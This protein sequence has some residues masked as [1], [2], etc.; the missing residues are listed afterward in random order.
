MKNTITLLGGDSRFEYASRYFS[1]RGYEVRQLLYNSDE[2]PESLG[3]TV[4]LPLPVMR[5]GFLFSPKSS[6]K[7]SENELCSVLA[8]SAS[9]FGG[10]VSESLIKKVKEKGADIV[11]YYKNEDLLRANATLTAESAMLLL[12]QEKIPV[13]NKRVLVLGFG[14]CGSELARLIKSAG[15]NVT[16]VTGKKTINGYSYFGFSS[17][18]ES[19]S[20]FDLVINTVPSQ[21]LGSEELKRMNKDSSVLEIASAPY[22]VDFDCAE[23]EKIRVIRAPSLPGRFF[24]ERAGE[25]IA[26]TIESL[27]GDG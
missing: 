19:I 15:G 14:R 25:A 3:S 12:E 2:L 22:G 11:D 21:V 13:K 6:V 26:Q 7:L 9:V 18:R 1:D 17:L 27:L 10:M 16:V 8:K 20:A 5:G 23:R 4:I 24:P